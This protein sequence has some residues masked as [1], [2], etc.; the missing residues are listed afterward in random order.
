[1]GS[2][3]SK[4]RILQQFLVK[5]FHHEK[6][7]DKAFR[8][9]AAALEVSGSQNQDQIGLLQSFHSFGFDHLAIDTLRCFRESEESLPTSM[10]NYEL[11]WRTETWD[12]PDNRADTV[13]TAL[14]RSLRAIYRE[15]DMQVLDY[16]IRTALY[17]E[18]ERLR[19]LGSENLVEIRMVSQNLL[20]LREIL[21][22]RRKYAGKL[23]Q[24]DN[25]DMNE[26]Q[27]F[28]QIDEGFE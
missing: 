28:L 17:D 13:G 24:A 23:Q 15:R 2:M 8:F 3:V 26:W 25:L 14:Y 12:L 5:R 20:C 27:S 10:M 4:H 1:M 21:Q 16:T 11:G 6:Q 22:W 19:S 18:M 9:H 7:Y